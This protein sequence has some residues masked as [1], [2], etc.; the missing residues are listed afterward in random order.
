M[1]TCLIYTFK[2]GLHHLPNTVS[3]DNIIN[4]YRESIKNNSKF[5]KHSKI[6]TTE[7]YV[8]VFNDIIDD[9]V[10]V[11]NNVETFFQDDLK[12]HVLKN[13]TPP[14]TLVDG[15]LLL[16]NKLIITNEDVLYETILTDNDIDWFTKSRD[17]FTRYNIQ[18]KFKYWKYFNYTYNLGILHINNNSFVNDFLSEYSKLRNWYKNTIHS[19]IPHLKKNNIVEI[20]TCTYFLSMYL[21]THNYSIN[22]LDKT[23]SFNHLRGIDLKIDFLKKIGKYK[24]EL[25]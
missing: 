21:E 15:D 1:E 10:T 19:T 4:L 2:E 24:N 23:N 11:G 13:E 9:I 18:S 16:N 20:I 22:V 7:N 17:Y 6:Y 3:N 5:H 8:S 14:F 25:I 12:F